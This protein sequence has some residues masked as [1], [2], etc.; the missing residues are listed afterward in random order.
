MNRT[1]ILKN[2]AGGEGSRGGH[3]IGHTTS[4]KPIYSDAKH[5]GHA[6][7]SKQEHGEAANLHKDLSEKHK[8]IAGS[9]AWND[10]LVGEHMKRHGFHNEQML[11]HERQSK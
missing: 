5:P 1:V 6:G 10:P 11:A 2:D 8:K 3:I 9:M 4:G 7:L